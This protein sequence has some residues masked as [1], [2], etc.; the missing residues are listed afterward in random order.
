MFNP[1]R[2]DSG[3]L[4][5]IYDGTASGTTIAKGD[6]LD[7]SSGYLQRATSG[8][9]EVRLVAME[10]VVTAGGA[11]EDILCIVTDGV[12]FEGS[13]AGN[14]AV[15]DRGTYYDL[16]DHDTLNDDA[17]SSDVFYVIDVVGAAADKKVLGYFVHNIA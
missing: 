13:T 14:S 7:W 12:Q 3:K 8:T 10:D 6:A 5:K 2:Y 9:T 4:V 16:T 15:A 1:I 17:S 11:H